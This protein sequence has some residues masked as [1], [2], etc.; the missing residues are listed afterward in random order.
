MVVFR[1]LFL[2]GGIVFD[3]SHALDQLFER[4]RCLF[5]HLAA[6]NLVLQRKSS[7][8]RPSPPRLT[9]LGTMSQLPPPP[10]PLHPHPTPASRHPPPP[11]PLPHQ[12]QRPSRRVRHFSRWSSRQRSPRARSHG[13]IPTHQDLSS[14]PTLKSHRTWGTHSPSLCELWALALSVSKLLYIYM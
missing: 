10:H 14:T 13:A 9:A 11:R 8:L 3:H 7:Q 4:C 5:V 12:W 2:E 6:T 1:L